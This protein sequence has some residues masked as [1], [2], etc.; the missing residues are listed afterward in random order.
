MNTTTTDQKV[1][2]FAVQMV[3][4]GTSNEAQERTKKAMRTTL[5]DTEQRQLKHLCRAFMMILERWHQER[6]GDMAVE[7][8]SA[9]LKGLVTPELS[10][11]DR[12]ALERQWP[13]LIDQLNRAWAGALGGDLTMRYGG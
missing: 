13:L 12:D 10:S 3:R 6:P 5:T 7:E 8:L 1:V 2:D 9:Q 4:N 11:V